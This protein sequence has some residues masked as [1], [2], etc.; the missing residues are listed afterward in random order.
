MDK[1][2][3]KEFQYYLKNQEELVKQYNG[4]FIVIKSES[5]IG[6][7]ST[8]LEA[9]QATIQAGHEAGTFLVQLC[10]PGSE[11]YSQSFQTRVAFA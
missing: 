1:P 5:V 2:L 10:T 3:S 6:A 8:E 7:Y 4:K 9:I 11:G